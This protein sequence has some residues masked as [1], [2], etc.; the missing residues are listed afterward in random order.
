VKRLSSRYKVK[1]DN[2]G[3]KVIGELTG[4]PD[5]RLQVSLFVTNSELGARHDQT[6]LLHYPETTRG[7]L[8]AFYDG[9]DAVI[10]VWGGNKV[11]RIQ[12]PL[13]G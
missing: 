10:A 11:A 8:G 4:A 12:A 3:V 13:P 2:M 1:V 9:I 6:G 5:D 7:D